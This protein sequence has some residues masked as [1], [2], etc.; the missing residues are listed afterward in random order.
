MNLCKPL[1]KIPRHLLRRDHS[2]PRRGYGGRSG[3]WILGAI[4]LL[5]SCGPTASPYQ[6]TDALGCLE[7]APGA[8]IKIGVIQNL[9]GEG[10]RD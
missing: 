10:P 6:C 2:L 5:G 3:L 8:P 9:T 1:S 7:I 4:L